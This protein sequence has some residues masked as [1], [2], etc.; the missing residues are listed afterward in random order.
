MDALDSLIRIKELE[1][2]EKNF[3]VKIDDLK[4]KTQLPILTRSRQERKLQHLREEIRA[5]VRLAHSEHFH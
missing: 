2:S 3:L 1:T 4:S 5:M